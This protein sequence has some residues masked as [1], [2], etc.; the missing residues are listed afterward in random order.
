MNLLVDT[1]ILVDHLRSDARAHAM[2][3]A[4]T[5]GGDELWGSVVSRAEVIRGMRSPERARTMILLDA[6]S[7]LDVTQAIA[8]RAGELAR[9]YRRSHRGVDLADFLIAAAAEEVHGRLVTRNVKH[10]PMFPD[11]EPPY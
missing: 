9:A 8:D 10:F 6:I 5:Q 3:A 1:S 7:W 4:A 11:L 2:L